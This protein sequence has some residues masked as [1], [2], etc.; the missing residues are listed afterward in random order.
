MYSG[1]VAY[2]RERVDCWRLLSR[3]HVSKQE[4]EYLLPVEMQAGGKSWVGV[5]NLNIADGAALIGW[6]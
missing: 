4:L 6:S 3:Y 5:D 1:N 2:S